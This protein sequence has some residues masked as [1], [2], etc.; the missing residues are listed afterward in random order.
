MVAS[1]LA[2]PSIPIHDIQAHILLMRAMHKLQINIQPGGIHFDSQSGAPL[3]SDS[4]LRFLHHAVQRFGAWMNTQKGIE[5]R[6]PLTSLSQEH[7]PPLDVLMIWH[8]YMLSPFAYNEDAQGN[9][10]ALGKLGGMPWDKLVRHL[11]SL[12][13]FFRNSYISFSSPAL[14]PR[15]W[16]LNL[17]KRSLLTGRSQPNSP[18]IS[19]PVYPLRNLSKRL[20]SASISLKQYVWNLEMPAIC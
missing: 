3:P 13:E 1:P 8:A 7:I 10:P 5:R 9:I 16:N 11:I 14:I 12:T 6:P 19:K 18:S 20:N 2:S 15:H 17:L 4:M